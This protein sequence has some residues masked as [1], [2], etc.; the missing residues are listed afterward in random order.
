MNDSS[1]WL[2]Q[3][4]FDRLAAELA[5]REGPLREEIKKK[6]AAAREEGDLSENAGYH[7]ARDAQGKNEARV[8]VLKHKL[9]TAQIGVPAGAEGVVSVGHKVTIKR[10]DGSHETFLLG[11]RE[12]VAH[13]EIDVYSPDSP[14]GKALVGRAV[15]ESATYEL[16]NGRGTLSVTVI[17]AVSFF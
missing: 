2:T 7:A 6:I 14:L 13:V 10:D 8:K 15:G 9:E 12:E 17:E 3:D 11:S 16:P 1:N 5:E 4:A